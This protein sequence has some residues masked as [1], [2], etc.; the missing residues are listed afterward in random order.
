[1]ARTDPSGADRSLVDPRAGMV[2]LHADDAGFVRAPTPLVYRRLADVARWPTWWTGTRVRP[3]P[4]SGGDETW[5]LEL[6]GVF[7]RRLRLTARFHRWRPDRG[8]ELAVRGDLDG[9]S[10][11]WLEPLEGGT[12]VHHVLDAWAPAGRGAAVLRD[13]R[14]AVRRGLWG[15][16]DLLHLEARTSA[17]LRP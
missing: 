11:F 4:P 15:L 10:E 12:V 9:R 7:A 2:R 17:G 6:T 8:V 3:R 13:H 16:K 1:M 14:R 5:G